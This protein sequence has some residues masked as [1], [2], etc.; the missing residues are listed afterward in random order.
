MPHNERNTSA[1][2]LPPRAVIEGMEHRKS[3]ESDSLDNVISADLL[4]ETK[5]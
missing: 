3:P 1:I 2:N 5:L 4:D